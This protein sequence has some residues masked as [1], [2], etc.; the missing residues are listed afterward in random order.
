[1]GHLRRGASRGHLHVE[2][3]LPVGAY[4]LPKAGRQRRCAERDRLDRVERDV[5]PPVGRHRSDQ[6]LAESRD[7]GELHYEG[8]EEVAVLV[9][10]DVPHRLVVDRRSILRRRGIPS[11]RLQVLRG[12]IPTARARSEEGAAWSRQSARPVD[13]ATALT[14]AAMLSAFM[15]DLSLAAEQARKAVAVAEQHGY[16]Q[17]RALGRIIAAWAAAVAQPDTR[18][19][20]D[21]T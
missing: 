19:L 8:P 9:A 11:K 6:V 5:H 13:R 3:P 20:A 1:M 12:H 14:L 18:S 17:W 15:D 2:R 16:R 7:A 10:L 21:V 4:H